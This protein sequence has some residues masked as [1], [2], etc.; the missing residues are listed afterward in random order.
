M[1]QRSV[2][3]DGK[4][5][6]VLH[7][8]DRKSWMRFFPGELEDDTRKRHSSPLG[9]YNRIGWN[10]SAAVMIELLATVVPTQ[11]KDGIQ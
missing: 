10:I 9:N 2:D 1:I 11:E 5:A 3:D 6:N 4:E 8:A 7:Q